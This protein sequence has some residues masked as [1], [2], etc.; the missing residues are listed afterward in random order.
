MHT[1]V[2]YYIAASSCCANQLS[3]NYLCQPIIN[4]NTYFVVKG[5]MKSV[6]IKL[7]FLVLLY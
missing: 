3:T 6:F 7:Y 1:P 4:E 2:V 5:P